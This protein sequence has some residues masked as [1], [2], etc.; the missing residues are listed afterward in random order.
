MR[1]IDRYVIRQVLMPFIIG[2]LV[3]TFLMML[4]PLQTYAEGLISKGVPPQTIAYLLA[5]LTPQALALTIPMSLLLG[6]LVGFGRLS[7]DREFV[8][9]QACGVSLKRL[10]LP[11]SI[12]SLFSMA[13]TGYMWFYGY[14]IANETFLDVTFNLVADRAEGN[15]KPRVFFREFPNLMLYVREVPP[16]GEGWNGVFLADT[17]PGQAEATYLARHGR[18]VIDRKKKTVDLVL[19]NVVRRTLDAKGA[20]DVGRIDHFIL[21]VDPTTVFPPPNQVIKGLTEMTVPELREAAAKR[22]REG[23]SSHNEW[24]AIHQKFAIPFACVVFGVIGLALGATHRRDGALGSF[25]L[26]LIVVFAY[27]I[28]MFLGPQMAKSALVPPWLAAW[29]PNILLG[30]LAGAMFL[31]RERVADQPIRLPSFIARRVARP[32]I[33]RARGRVLRIL[34][35]YVAGMY[36]RMVLLSGAAL[37]AVFYISTFIDRADKIFKGAATPPM[38]AAYFWYLTP[39][40]VYYIIPLAVL[41]GTLITI[42]VLTR[43]SEL[44]VMKACGVSLYRIAVPM[45]LAAV[46]TGAVLFALDAT[47]VGPYFAQAERLRLTM[48]GQSSAMLN[49]LSYGWVQGDHDDFYYFTYYDPRARVLGGLAHYEFSPGMTSMLRHTHA[50][51]ATYIS[52]VGETRGQWKVSQGWSRDFNAGGQVTGFTP[53]TNETREFQAP[54]YYGIEQ[55]DPEYLAF[56]DLRRYTARMIASGYN[57]A[58]EQTWIARR[59]AFPVATLIMTLIAVPFAV[60]IGRGGAMAGI[61]V[62][63]ALALV[64]WVSISIFA[65]LGGGGL[66]APT[67]AAWAP[68]MLFGAAALYLLLTVRT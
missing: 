54:A 68:N 35:G 15:V 26:G 37:M 42:A 62:G 18:V 25:V 60:T 47:I 2:L 49:P 11:V 21:S 46:A 23:L 55:P 34:D 57:M 50:D 43:S 31:W 67:L 65:A 51:A 27:Y 17:R 13:A 63:I 19:D 30:A 14:P 7:A 6:L 36:V 4:K 5:L 44:I 39:Q 45:F 20:Y 64:Y 1:I 38:L 66:I 41:L 8:A 24:V 32:K 61:A 58:K 59:L 10:L 52:P 33:A 28:P 16:T 56:G 9:M 22:E 53:I 29:L 12:V 3:F 40:Y 48:N